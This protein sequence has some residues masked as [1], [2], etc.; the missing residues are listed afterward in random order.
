MK[1]DSRVDLDLIQTTEDRGTGY[2]CALS[3]F[4]YGTNPGNFSLNGEQD[5]II[6]TTVL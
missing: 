1:I 2:R 4:S 3:Y 5:M 6:T